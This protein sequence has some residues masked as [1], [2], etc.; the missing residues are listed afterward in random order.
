MIDPITITQLAMPTIPGW[1]PDEATLPVPLPPRLSWRYPTDAD[2]HRLAP[3]DTT[4][5]TIDGYALPS[6][7]ARRSELVYG[8]APLPLAVRRGPFLSNL[9]SL[10][11]RLS[12]DFDA[13]MNAGL[14]ELFAEYPEGFRSVGVLTEY[15]QPANKMWMPLFIER[16]VRQHLKEDWDGVYRGCCVWTNPH[17]VTVVTMPLASPD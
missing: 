11:K 12:K 14:E 5:L 1:T 16:M 10:D 2:K 7:A 13:R 17:E 4:L 6:W 9:S 3:R 15:F 8:L